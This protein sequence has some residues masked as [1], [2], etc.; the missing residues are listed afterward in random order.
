MGINGLALA[1]ALSAIYITTMLV[2]LLLKKHQEFHLKG[3][4][5]NFK[6]IVIAS[7]ITALVMLTN[8]YL[9]G[10]YSILL[11]FSLG[12]LCCYNNLLVLCVGNAHSDI[13]DVCRYD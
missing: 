10:D 4:F 6:G 12:S 5:K 7:F 9:M 2:I 8:K 13:H 1:T 11:Q 3:F